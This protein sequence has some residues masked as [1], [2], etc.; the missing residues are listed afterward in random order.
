[1]LSHHFTLHLDH[2]ERQTIHIGQ[3]FLQLLLSI[4][5]LD[6][7]TNLQQLLENGGLIL[8][9]WFTGEHQLKILRHS[10]AYVIPFVHDFV[11]FDLPL[12]VQD[13]DAVLGK[14]CWKHIQKHPQRIGAQ[15]R[16]NS[17]NDHERY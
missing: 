11:H 9:C 3:E 7:W 10:L 2:W 12:F 14:S 15:V 5:I 8:L 13:G 1:M 16:E 4:D 17:G 6:R